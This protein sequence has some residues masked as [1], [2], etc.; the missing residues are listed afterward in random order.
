MEWFQTIWDRVEDEH[1]HGVQINLEWLAVKVFKSG[2]N[3][4]RR[5]MQSVIW[6][7]LTNNLSFEH[8]AHL[9]T[10]KA[11]LVSTRHIFLLKFSCELIIFIEFKRFISISVTFCYLL[12]IFFAQLLL[13]ICCIASQKYFFCSLQTNYPPWILKIPFLK[14]TLTN[15]ARRHYIHPKK[16]RNIS[17][18]T[19]RILVRD[20][21]EKLLVI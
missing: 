19:T 18:R 8:A 11:E 17:H 9:K 12:I 1:F 2:K 6:N 16:F 20:I 5:L 4:L 21:Y 3:K 14:W 15:Q 13:I 7:K 10:I